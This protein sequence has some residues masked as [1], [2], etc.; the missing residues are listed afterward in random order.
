MYV[1]V[2]NTTILGAFPSELCEVASP[3]YIP[4][5]YVGVYQVKLLLLFINYSQNAGIRPAMLAIGVSVRQGNFGKLVLS[6]FHVRFS[7]HTADRS[8]LQQ[9]A[10]VT[11]NG[12][13]GRLLCNKTFSNRK[14]R[15]FFVQNLRNFT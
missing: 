9:I 14:F 4:T 2:L 6:R 5:Y 12:K 11:S 3:G 1:F 10:P 13:N 7:I 15:I 8:I